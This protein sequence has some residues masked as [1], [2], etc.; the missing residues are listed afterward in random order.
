MALNLDR[1]KK[2]RESTAA[3][4]GGVGGD[5]WYP[6]PGKNIIR[7]FSFEHE[8][9]DED[10]ELGRYSKADDVQVGDK[11]EDIDV[12]CP[13]HFIKG[14]PYNCEGPGCKVCSDARKTNDRQLR[15]RDR[16]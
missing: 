8:L 2:K 11:V 13:I 15:V 7:I 9:T 5:F 1:Y 6:R 4:S 16:F 12:F 3:R 14:Q 10:F